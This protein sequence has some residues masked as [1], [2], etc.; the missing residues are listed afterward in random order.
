MKKFIFLVIAVIIVG[1]AVVAIPDLKKDEQID[2]KSGE[3]NEDSPTTDSSD[4]SDRLAYWFPQHDSV[5][6]GLVCL[7]EEL[8]RTDSAIIYG[9]NTERAE[10]FSRCKEVLVQ[11]FDSIHSGSTLSNYIKADSML[12]EI[13]AFFEKDA[14]LST[15]GMIVNLDLQSDFILYRMSAESEQIMTFDSTIDESKDWG[16]LQKAMTDFCLGIV[17]ADWFGGSGVGPASLATRNSILETRLGDLKRINKLCRMDFPSRITGAREFGEQI[18]KHLAGSVDQFKKTIEQTAKSI[19]TADEAKEWLPED[20][21]ND[22]KTLYDK[23]QASKEPLL[24]ALS[25]WLV[26]RDKTPKCAINAEKAA[27]NR[28]KEITAEMVDSLT[29]C[30]ADSHTDSQ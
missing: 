12:T 28:Y 30:I 18:E 7:A 14:D 13:E 21:L 29:S 6:H 10:W 8:W 3:E 24:K 27:R 23:I 1:I 22:Y 19:D 5:N 25:N 20:R 26:A 2:V 16:Y 15:M 11:G 4:N 9:S 17:Q